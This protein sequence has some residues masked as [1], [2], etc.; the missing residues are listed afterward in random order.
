[1]R[2]Q[3]TI[4]LDPVLECTT[5]CYVVLWC[6]QESSKPTSFHRFLFLF[7]LLFFISI[8]VQVLMK[9]PFEFITTAQIFIGFLFF[10]TSSFFFLFCLLLI[11]C[12]LQQSLFLF[13][14]SRNLLC[15]SVGITHFS[16]YS[17]INIVNW[18]Q[19]RNS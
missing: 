4:N 19:L 5:V 15:N 13:Y 18:I 8:Y 7:I 1:M 6:V 12:A 11:C 2:M 14:F 10:Y 3:K 9:N 16:F 17:L